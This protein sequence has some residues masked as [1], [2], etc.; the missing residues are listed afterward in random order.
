MSTISSTLGLDVRFEGEH[1][2]DPRR[3]YP[4][5]VAGAR[6][7]PLEDSGG[8]EIFMDRQVPG[9]LAAIRPNESPLDGRYSGNSGEKTSI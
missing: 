3:R 9:M 7:A 6:R 8:A 1:A 2:F 5:C 4:R